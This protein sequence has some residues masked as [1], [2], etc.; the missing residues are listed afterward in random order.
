MYKNFIAYSM[1]LSVT[2]C[3]LLIAPS[4]AN[5]SV[6]EMPQNFEQLKNQRLDKIDAI[7]ACV[8][9]SN[10]VEDLKSCIP[11]QKSSSSF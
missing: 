11:Q 2:T 4:L 10:N 3:G 6:S 1:F 5:T 9:K 8:V 7:R